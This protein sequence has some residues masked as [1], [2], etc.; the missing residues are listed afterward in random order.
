[1]PVL[2]MENCFYISN[3]LFSIAANMVFGC[4]QNL[5]WVTNQIMSLGVSIN[6]LCCSSHFMKFLCKDHLY[7]ELHDTFLGSF[8]WFLMK[9][10]FFTQNV[11]V[12]YFC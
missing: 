4:N 10:V 2:A 6:V 5:I 7:T 3:G 1:M 11:N 8:V 12:G 9:Y